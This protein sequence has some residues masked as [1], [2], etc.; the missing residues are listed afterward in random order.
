MAIRFPVLISV[1]LAA[2]AVL[3]TPGRADACFCAAPDTACQ[4][5][6]DYWKV[7]AVFAGRVSAIDRAGSKDG[8]RFLRSRTVRFRVAESFR[9]IEALPG[10]EVV[11]LTGSGGGDCGYPFREGREYLVY[12]SRNEQTGELT[13]SICSRTRALEDA[14][15]DL[16]YARGVVAGRAPAGGITGAVRLVTVSIDGSR[17]QE[18]QLP[19]VR[20]TVSGTG[21]MRETVSDA[22]GTF[23]VDGLSAGRYTVSVEAPAAHYALVDPEDFDFPDPRACVDVR[24]E[25]RHDGRVAGRVVDAAGVAVPGLTIDLTTP[26]ELRESYGS[27]LTAVTGEDGAFEVTR[28]PPGRYVVGLNTETRGSPGLLTL[29]P[30]VDDVAGAKVIEVDPGG[31]VSIGTWQLP[32]DLKFLPITGTVVEVSGG[33]AAGTLVYLR[34]PGSG[35]IIGFPVTADE[36]GRFAIAALAGREYEIFA[37]GRAGGDGGVS[38]ASSEPLKVVGEAGLAPVT[39]TLRRRY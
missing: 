36:R 15:S 21:G 24:V 12:A 13:A 11:V 8:A 4:A 3:V 20:V 7:G 18:Q 30:G 32:K 31:P 22:N 39:L 10:A 2:A 38:R 9:G 17:K 6:A 26:A 28:V 27:R 25:V 35:R 34:D 19:G 37:E 5:A 33:L 23:S 29:Y 14:S 1:V 16:E